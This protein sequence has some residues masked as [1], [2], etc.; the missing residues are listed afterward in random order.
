MNTL[1]QLW[2]TVR[3]NPFFVAFEGGA[4]GSVLN[5]LDDGITAGH[6]DFSRA[7]IHKLVTVAL[8]GGILAVRLLYRPAPGSNPKP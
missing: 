5:F 6:L 4:V 3:S 8:S 1:K 2:L 7:G